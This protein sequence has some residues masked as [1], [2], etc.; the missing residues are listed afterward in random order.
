M[1]VKEK[2]RKK[3]LKIRKRKYFEIK[4]S[5]FNPLISLVKKKLKRKKI[6]LSFYYPSNFETNVLQIVN[7]NF[8]KNVT[9]LLPVI[10]KKII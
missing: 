1:A 6:L 5:F 8:F 4:P 7:N 2:L 9:T 10:E 3:F